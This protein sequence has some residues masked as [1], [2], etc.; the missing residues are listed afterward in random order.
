MSRVGPEPASR[1]S[2]AGGSG[3][4]RGAPD[5]GEHAGAKLPSHWAEEVARRH[6]EGLGWRTLAR[7]Y[8]LRGGELDLVM[9]AGETVVVVEVRQRTTAR[10]G[11]P[12]ETIDRRKLTRLRRTAQHYLAFELQRPEAPLRLDA[13]LLLGGEQRHQLRHLENIG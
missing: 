12:A 11:T 7:N 1:R 6:L 5:R 13:V 9:Q 10:F 8:R 2:A 4:G 3:V